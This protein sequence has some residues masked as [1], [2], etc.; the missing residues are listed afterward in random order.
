MR[1]ISLHI[2]L[3]FVVLAAMTVSCGKDRVRVIP[4]STLAKIYAEM[5]VT[6]QWIASAPS[7]KRIADTSLVYEPILEKYGYTSEDYRKSVERYLDDPERFS[8]IFRT[9]SEILDVRIKE[10]KKLLEIEEKKNVKHDFFIAVGHVVPDIENIPPSYTPDS[11]VFEL[12]TALMYFRVSYVER[13]DTVYR[14][15]E[16]VVRTDTVAVR[17]S[18][19]AID[20]LPP[21]PHEPVAEPDAVQPVKKSVPG[22]LHLLPGSKPAL[23]KV[24]ADTLAD[25]TKLIL[26]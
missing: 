21:V 15:P 13:Y 19:C 11:L 1:R 16:F 6:D 12:D 20:S 23:R 5:L 25:R 9:A 17:D 4:R 18:I 3:V 24:E 10:L 26:D 14:G 2:I 7:V 22:P 8:R